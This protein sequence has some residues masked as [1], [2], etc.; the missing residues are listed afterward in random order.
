[1]C[2]MSL[3]CAWVSERMICDVQEPSGKLSVS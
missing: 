2:T 3:E 1:M